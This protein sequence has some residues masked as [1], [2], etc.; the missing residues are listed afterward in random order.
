MDLREVLWEGVDWMHLAEDRDHWSSLVNTIIN[1]RIPQKA[2][3]F[4]T[5]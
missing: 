3:N 4:L 5:S 1:F 2:G